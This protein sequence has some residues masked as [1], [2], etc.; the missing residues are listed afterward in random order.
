M[1]NNLDHTCKQWL[2][3][4]QYKYGEFGNFV[5]YAEKYL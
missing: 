1:N 3:D 2:I 5:R 4:D